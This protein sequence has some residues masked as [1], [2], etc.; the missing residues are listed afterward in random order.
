MRKGRISGDVFN[1][2]KIALTGSLH[3]FL[4]GVK[5]HKTRPEVIPDL[6]R[7]P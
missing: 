1:Q 4:E 3:Q 5:N 6:S 2:E 7:A